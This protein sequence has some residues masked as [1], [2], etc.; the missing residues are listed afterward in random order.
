MSWIQIN[1]REDLPK[2][3]CECWVI[4]RCERITHETY[5]F[6]LGGFIT[7]LTMSIRDQSRRLTH[8]W[9]IEKPVSP[10]QLRQKN[11]RY[12]HYRI[13][14]RSYLDAN[15][16]RAKDSIKYISTFDRYMMEQE[17]WSTMYQHTKKRLFNFKI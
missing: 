8:Y 10:K 3:Q 17:C 6:G 14:I 12:I 2:T 11:L 16:N 7:S 13:N 1:S 5:Y 9:V 15:D 4:D